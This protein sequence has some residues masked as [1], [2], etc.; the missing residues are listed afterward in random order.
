MVLI[1]TCLFWGWGRRTG[2]RRLG[3]ATG[4]LGLGLL[5]QK[6]SLDVGQD[7]T[8]GDGH[9]GQ[10]LVQ[11]LVVADGQL[12]VTGDDPGLLVVTGS[13][14]SQLENFSAE[15]FQDGSEV[16]GCTSSY[17]LGVVSVSEKTVNTTDGEL[18]PGTG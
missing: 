10:K 17:S 8:L 5:G 13:V 6:H 14:S 18:K 4:G 1:R 12:K 16:H 9:A 11:L 15:V 2:V 7:T 3:L